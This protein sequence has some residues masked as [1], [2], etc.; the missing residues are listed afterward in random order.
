MDGQWVS[1]GAIVQLMPIS[2]QLVQVITVTIQ[3]SSNNIP[4]TLTSM[5]NGFKKFHQTE[6]SGQLLN[7]DLTSH[8]RD[9]I[10]QV[11]VSM[12]MNAVAM[13]KWQDGFHVLYALHHH[14]IHYVTNRGGWSPCIIA[15]AAVECCLHLDIP[16]SALEVM[17]GAQWVTGSNQTEKDKRNTI[18]EKLLRACLSKKEI[19]GAEETL[20]AMELTAKNGELFQL[21]LSAAKQNGNTDIYDRLSK[22]NQLPSVIVNTKMPSFALE[23][24][25]NSAVKLVRLYNYYL[26]YNQL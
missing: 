23:P 15:M 6:N 1:L 4:N 5:I 24:V 25:N 3:S 20:R 7:G 11:G 21:V 16:Q 13:E 22:K 14:G 2:L 18:L 17:R 26:S 19:A 8:D 9:L 12:I 10:G